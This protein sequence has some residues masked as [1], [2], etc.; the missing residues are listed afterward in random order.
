M[1]RD[2]YSQAPY[3]KYAELYT[4]SVR[5]LLK[6]K[7]GIILN[8]GLQNVLFY[9]MNKSKVIFMNYSETKIGAVSVEV[10]G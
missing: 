7:R 5:I 4:E 10:K 6:V 1:S 9:S 3:R 2:P 8:Y